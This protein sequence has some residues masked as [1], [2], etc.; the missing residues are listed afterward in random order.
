MYQQTLQSII[1]YLK[2]PTK[3]ETNRMMLWLC[4]CQ[5]IQ[6][7]PRF[8][9]QPLFFGYPTHTSW[10]MLGFSWSSH[11][12]GIGGCLI[13]F[14]GVVIEQEQSHIPVRYFPKQGH[15]FWQWLVIEVQLLTHLYR[16]LICHFCHWVHSPTMLAKFPT[17]PK[18][19]SKALITLLV[20]FLKSSGMVK[21]KLFICYCLLCILKTC[22]H[23]QIYQK[24]TWGIRTSL[25]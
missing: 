6:A 15:T 17:H 5:K 2:R 21:G 14:L 18:A 23:F 11:H 12:G 19:F 7:F 24:N 20:F 22:V 10:K 4:M 1:S 9:L 3:L 8:H 25:F 16:T 13:L